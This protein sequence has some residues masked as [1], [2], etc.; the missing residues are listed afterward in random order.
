M[1]QN[2]TAATSNGGCSEDQS[3]RDLL[4]EGLECLD[5]GISIFDSNLRLTHFNNK[6]IQVLD[7]PRELV[8]P[9]IGLDDV[10]RYNAK[11]GDY[12][13]GDVEQMVAER[14]AL[15]DKGLPHCFERTLADGR[16]IEVN[17]KPL[18]SGG[19]VTT[20]KDVTENQRTHALKEMLGD[21]VEKSLNEIYVFDPVTF[22]FIE[23]NH[24]ARRN[25][26][27]SLEELRR[28][29]P[30]DIKPNLTLRAFEELIEP[31]QR[32]TL[33]KITYETIHVRADGSKYE[34]EVHLQLMNADGQPVF[35]AIIQDITQRK[36]AEQSIL[37][38]RDA[39][40]A[41]N[42]TKSEFL[43]NMSHELRTPLNSILG[44]SEAMR[45][46]I[47]GPHSNPKY[48]D[49]A[50]SIHQS[51]S[52]LL[53]IINDI[54]DVSKIESG[55]MELEEETVSVE[56]IISSSIAITQGRA[57][58]KGLQLS[59][60]SDPDLP[61]IYADDRRLK[62]ILINLLTNSIKFTGSGGEVTITTSYS[63][64]DG[65]HITVADTGIG[66]P[67]PQQPGI[68]QP[69][70]KVESSTARAHEGVGL[71]LSIVKALIE[72]HD[73]TVSLKSTPGIGTSITIRLPE[74]RCRTDS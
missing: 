48:Q 19:F 54:L 50:G 30:L 53:G 38:S 7:L 9:G 49:Y 71:G 8:R 74:E 14:M 64:G 52:L 39:A 33:E 59:V 15:A 46:C 4:L 10:F 44:F 28:M 67:L 5:Y 62:Q 41:A 69:F 37:T 6:L 70:A 2:S 26:G 61:Q 72:Q 32:R 16:I 25:L 23:V 47:L 45:E 20:Y 58:E 29:T 12:G 63:E 57:V 60:L 24:G 31:L 66:I 73:G 34:V 22:K 68:F 36:Q 17:G 21:I 40:L 1:T 56:E 18:P 35:V 43:A 27:Y 55:N 42:R 65:L 3:Q 13:P 51:G 11:R